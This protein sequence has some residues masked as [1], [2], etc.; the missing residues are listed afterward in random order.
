MLYKMSTETDKY[1][2]KLK[3]NA[4]MGTIAI[5]VLYAII[6]FI[7]ILY[8]NLTEQGKALYSDLKPFAVTFIF[9]T[10]IIIVAI[11][12]MVF[13][14]QPEQAKKKNSDDFILTNKLDCPDYFKLVKVTGAD[15]D[16]P[17]PQT[18][19]DILLSGSFNIKENKL[20]NEEDKLKLFYGSKNNEYV[21]LY[22]YAITNTENIQNKCVYDA[23][24]VYTG[25]TDFKRKADI[26][27]ALWANRENDISMDGTVVSKVVDNDVKNAKKLAAMTV[28]NSGYTCTTDA[29]GVITGCTISNPTKPG[30]ITDYD[31]TKVYPEYLTYLDAKE[32]A[33]NNETG[34]KNL[35][36][37]QWSEVCGVPWSAAGC[38]K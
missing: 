23:D 26:V 31:C 1:T 25:E 36:R 30:A 27:T 3:Y 10:I 20:N 9:G 11:T 17:A 21:D 29:G 18:D 19:A 35:H 34:P 6:A 32:Y 16:D 22:D 24:K 38:D 14:W 7:M 15:Q 28:M 13:N 4:F 33:K 12:I 2:T 37:C 8:I 5:C